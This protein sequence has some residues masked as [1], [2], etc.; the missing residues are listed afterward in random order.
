M[1]EDE[2]ALDALLDAM[3]DEDIDVRK[4]ALWAVGHISG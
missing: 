1:I 4:Q 2:T 3:T